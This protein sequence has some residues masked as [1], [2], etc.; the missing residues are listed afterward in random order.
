MT[1]TQASN[2]AMLAR[3][4]NVGDI[5]RRGARRTPNK[6][7]VVMGANRISYRDLD[8]L[9]NRLAN[10]LIERGLGKGARISVLGRNSIEFLILYFATAKAGATLCPANPVLPDSELRYLLQHVEADAV[11]VDVCDLPRI[12]KLLPELPNLKEV[13][14]LSNAVDAEYESIES[15][16]LEQPN[17][18]PEVTVA[19][20]DIAIIMYT[21]G[22]TSAPKGAMLS[23]LSITTGAMHFALA[24]EMT[25]KTIATAI[26]PLFHCAQL[27][28]SSGTLI[29]GGTVVVMNSFDADLLL[30]T[31]EEERITWMFALPAMYRTLL[32]AP[33]LATTDLSSLDF[34]LYGMT[35]IDRPTLHHAMKAFGARFALTSGQ[36]EAYPPTVVFSPEFQLSKEG[37]YWGRAMPLVEIAIMDD[38]GNI[39]PNGEVGEIVYRGPMLLEGYLK[40]EEATAKAFKWGWFHSGDLGR[41]D[42]DDLLMFVDRKKDIV[43]SGGE[44]VSSIKVEAVLLSHPTVMAAA[45]VGVPHPKWG[46][47]VVAAVTLR[48]KDA[49]EPSELIAYCKKRLAPYE[50]PKKVE[51]FEN[52]PKTA[53]GKIQKFELRSRLAN[54]FK[55]V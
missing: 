40:D 26:L 10:A 18:D 42:T 39:L 53:T 31:I 33:L 11:F 1:N 51:L 47:A 23:H 24:G 49:L 8:A 45:V 43:K 30:R 55:E 50:V 22:T 25:D 17:A 14:L 44:N 46:E 54:V 7:A 37:S 15:L 29:R 6:T 41:F 52:L 16:S 19:D 48:T 12:A 36:T 13:I 3:R 38:N 34:C 27:S 28:I 5:I 2:D 4:V 32:N 21:S 9:S 35:P 20:R